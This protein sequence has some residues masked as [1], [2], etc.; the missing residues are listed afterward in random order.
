MK[1]RQTIIAASV[2]ALL[3][4]GNAFARETHELHEQ[5]WNQVK[6]YGEVL[7]ADDSVGNW[8]PWA[9]FVEPA[10]GAPSPV[11][12]LGASGFDPYKNIPN[13]VEESGCTAGSW[14]G[15]AIFRDKARESGGDY[16]P[17]AMAREGMKSKTPMNAGLFALAFVADPSITAGSGR[18]DG[19][20]FWRL[21]SLD[22][23][24]VPNFTNSGSEIPVYFGGGKDN[25]L[26]H[27]RTISPELEALVYSDTMD[28]ASASGFSHKLRSHEAAWGLGGTGPFEKAVAALY[29]DQE[30]GR[31]FRNDEVAVGKF[32]RQVETYTSGE[33]VRYAE[34]G[35]FSSSSTGGYYVVGIATPQAY[36]AGQQA[37]NISASYSGGSFDGSRQGYVAID[38]QFGTATWNG[39]WSSM[40]KGTFGFEAAGTIS[41]ANINATSITPDKGVAT[42]SSYVQGTFYGQTAGSIGGVS[43]VTRTASIPT[44]SIESRV[45]IPVTT[46]TQNAIF[47]VNKIDNSRN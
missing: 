46:Q 35:G 3:V 6:S 8:G 28:S 25:G 10:A 45:A 31:W 23:L 33:E 44:P 7:L 4:N 32:M 22:T 15:Y 38:V 14:C 47:L 16:P 21:T 42:A 18:G 11:Q 37:Q 20:V 12:M 19:S 24:V 39:H 9:D 34:G 43:S 40:G 27:F 2:A 36:L 17:A 5:L 26:H 41:G 1:T 13:T 29:Y 30:Q